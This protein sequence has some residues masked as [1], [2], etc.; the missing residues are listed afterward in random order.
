[1]FVRSFV[2]VT[3]KDKEERERDREKEKKER[4]KEKRKNGEEKASLVPR[5]HT[6]SK[7]K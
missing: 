6:L 3:C 2:R 5:V 1:M 4:K 7:E